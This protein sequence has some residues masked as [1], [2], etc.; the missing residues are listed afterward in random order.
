MVDE[1]PE[2][3]PF[4]K[5]AITSFIAKRLHNTNASM[6]LLRCIGLVADKM[7]NGKERLKRATDAEQFTGLLLV[8]VWDVAR[9][10]GFTA[11]IDTLKDAIKINKDLK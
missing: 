6:D 5:A 11:V 3:M 2:T 1:M 10:D 7:L 4:D 9:V 8:A